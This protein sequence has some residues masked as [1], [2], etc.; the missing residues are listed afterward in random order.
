[1]KE[2]SPLSSFGSWDEVEGQSTRFPL[3]RTT[4]FIS[5]YFLLRVAKCDIGGAIP[6][7]FKVREG[8]EVESGRVGV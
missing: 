7:I 3:I 4:F 1:M 6:S 8:A 2:T 5:L